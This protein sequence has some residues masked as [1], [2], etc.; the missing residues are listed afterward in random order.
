MKSEKH[1]SKED[2]AGLHLSEIGRRD[3]LKMG[4]GTGASVAISQMIP[5]S[6]AMAQESPNLPISDSTQPRA[7]WLN[8]GKQTGP[9][10]KNSANRAFGNGPMDETTREIV[11]YVSS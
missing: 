7:G 1:D 5:S 11:E 2:K 6:N 10:W 9:G 8:D 3:F 4:V